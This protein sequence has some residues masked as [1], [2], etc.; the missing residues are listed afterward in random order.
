MW[1]EVAGVFLAGIVAALG[2]VFAERKSDR[3]ANATAEPGLAIGRAFS[4]LALFGW[5][6]GSAALIGAGYGAFAIWYAASQAPE[7]RRRE[8]IE[9][10]AGIE[11]HPHLSVLL[12]VRQPLQTAPESFKAEKLAIIDGYKTVSFGEQP[13]LWLL[14]SREVRGV[15]FPAVTWTA[16]TPHGSKYVAGVRLTWSA[17]ITPQIHFRPD[18]VAYA[19]AGPSKAP[20]ENAAEGFRA[21]I[22]ARNSA[23]TIQTYNN[24]LVG[25][26]AIMSAL[27]KDAEV[28]RL[29]LVADD[30][31]RKAFETIGATW[32][33]RII[34]ATVCIPIGKRRSQWIVASAGLGD[35]VTETRYETYFE[36]PLV[37]KADP[38][39]VAASSGNEAPSE[40]RE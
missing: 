9:Q 10:L 28:A 34:D 25:A 12:R 39:L 36:Q 2:V 35:A 27:R 30:N 18:A 31:N 1:L 6:A 4:N 5:I 19:T 32:Q 40:C 23:I 15:L 13:D 22:Q 14:T 33:Q 26:A 20:K 11:L 16:P 3:A 37:L 24:R 8:S 21:E 29:W 38:E 7:K 17:L